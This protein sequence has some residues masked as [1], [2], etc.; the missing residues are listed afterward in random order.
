MAALFGFTFLYL[1]YRGDA[2][3]KTILAVPALGYGFFLL[4]KQRSVIYIYIYIKGLKEY[5][6]RKDNTIE[7]G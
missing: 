4:A 3:Y 7:L 6:L 2:K 5:S 1:L